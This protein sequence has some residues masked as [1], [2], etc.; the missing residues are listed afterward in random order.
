VILAGMP[1]R[2][3]L[4]VFVVLATSCSV[5]VF[6]ERG[7]PFASQVVKAKVCVLFVAAG[8][9]TEMA[10]VVP[11]VAAV[12]FGFVGRSEITMGFALLSMV[13]ETELVAA[14]I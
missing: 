13:M 12:Q 10:H 9:S 1:L 11:F 5:T 3:I 2:V 6:V 8:T 4:S 7:L 14:E